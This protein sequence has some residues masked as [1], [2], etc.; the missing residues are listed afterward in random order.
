MTQT[1]NSYK[2][3]WKRARARVWGTSD[4]VPGDLIELVT[5]PR[6]AQLSSR[7]PIYLGILGLPWVTFIFQS[8][9]SGGLIMF[10]QLWGKEQHRSN[11]RREGVVEGQ[12]RWLCCAK[13]HTHH[14]HTHLCYGQITSGMLLTSCARWHQTLCPATAWWSVVRQDIFCCIRLVADWKWLLFLALID[15]CPNL[16]IKN[17]TITSETAK[18]W[19]WSQHITTFQV[20]KCQTLQPP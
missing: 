17:P 13:T 9:F 7:Y 16:C 6:W 19:S 15:V 10:H 14:T 1:Y 20:K 2:L 8:G 11:A 18:A 5:V 3:R 4:L 12:C